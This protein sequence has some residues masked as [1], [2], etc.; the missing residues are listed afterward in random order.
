M[1]NNNEFTCALCQRTFPKGWTDEEAK[2]EKEELFP[3]TDV[4]DC[5]IVCHECF[6]EMEKLYRFK[7]HNQN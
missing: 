6:E 7:T 4:D 5:E 2:A 1:E 3:N